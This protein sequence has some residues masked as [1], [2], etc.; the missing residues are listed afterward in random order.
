MSAEKEKNE[1]NAISNVKLKKWKK[2][3]PPLQ[4]SVVHVSKDNVFMK[5]G[6]V[7]FK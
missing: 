4:P 1:I 6:V 7:T 5:Y 2:F 3:P